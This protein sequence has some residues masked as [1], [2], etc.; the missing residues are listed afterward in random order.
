MLLLYEGT[1]FITVSDTVKILLK[2]RGVSVHTLAGSKVLWFHL[3]KLKNAPNYVWTG[4]TLGSCSK[5]C[6]F[7]GNVVKRFHLH[8][9]QGNKCKRP[10]LIMP[11]EKQG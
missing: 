3:K 2:P 8:C 7:H 1:W 5:A 9:T 6:C 11:V 10:P 4:Q